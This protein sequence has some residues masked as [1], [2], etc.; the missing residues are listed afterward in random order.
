[1]CSFRKLLN[2]KCNF[3]KAY[4]QNEISS[5]FWG[6]NEILENFKY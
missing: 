2:L 6:Q 4:D 1:M 5:K 3:G